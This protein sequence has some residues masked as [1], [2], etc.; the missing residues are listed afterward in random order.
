ME[1]TPVNDYDRRTVIL[2]KEFGKIT[3][4]CRGARR[5]NNKMLAV[6]NPFS[7][8]T[9][10]LYEGKNAYNLIDADISFYFE[11]LRSDF[12]GA[13]LGMYFLEYAAYYTRENNDDVEM[14]RLLFQSVRALT[15]PDIDNRLIRAVYEI[16]AVAVNGE[17]PGIPK[18]REY[19]PG[20]IKAVS[21]I[22]DSSIERLYAFTVSD[23][24]TDEL[25]SL[26]DLYRRRFTDR[27]F[28]TLETLE[29]LC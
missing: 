20:T 29:I 5:L 2:T 21:Y 15:N 17:F 24:V 7:F 8:G 27:D 1:A 3:A 26:G 4:F 9:F 14:L 11:E 25:L 19:L 18:D 28:K 16:K 10:K 12:E 23:K 22:V 13:Y 6:T